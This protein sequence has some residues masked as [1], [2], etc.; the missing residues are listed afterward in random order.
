MEEQGK[1]ALFTCHEDPNYGSMLQ[2]YALA[3]AIKSLGHEV[4]YISYRNYPYQSWPIRAIKAVARYLGLKKNVH[5]FSFFDSPEFA[6]TMNAFKRFHRQHIP[7]SKKIYYSNTIRTITDHNEYTNYIIGSDQSWSPYLYDSRK[8]YFL[9]FAELPKRNAYAPS[10]GTTNISV[11]YKQLLKRKLAIFNHLSCREKSNSEMLSSLIGREVKNVL[12]PTLLLSSE[13]WN[14]IATTPKIKGEY[15]LAYILGE[16]NTIVKFADDLGNTTGL[17]V[18]YI[19]TRPKHLNHKNI[20]TGIGPDDFVGLVKHAKYVVTD[21][22]HGTLFCIIHKVQFY[23]F[24]KQKGDMNNK[25]NIRILEFL[26]TLHLEERFQDD[27]HATLLGNV[28]YKE[29][30]SILLSM[31]KESVAFLKLCVE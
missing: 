5:E 9:D 15:V 1:I 2:A 8:P 31:Q 16:K 10:L 27:N 19:V 7:S 6:D 25:D 28:N 24:S 4:E 17:P 21:S 22:F 13:E 26:K 20:L 30:H 23:A 18:Y 29:T 11:E 12:D 3:A 14:K